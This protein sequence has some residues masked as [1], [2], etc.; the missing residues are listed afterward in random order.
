MRRRDD[1][2]INSTQV[3]TGG[4]TFSVVGGTVGGV[5]SRA[6]GHVDSL[7]I[8]TPPPPADP[9]ELAAA[10][11]TL[12]QALGGAA[13]PEAVRA[14]LEE[15]LDAARRAVDRAQPNPARAADRLGAMARQLASHPA[16]AAVLGRL[17]DAALD[18]ATRMA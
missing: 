10:L 1:K 16:A 13:L 7:S 3:N 14:D 8:G 9:R 12:A 17:V 2:A 5:N 18:L 15:D 11:V 6:R 4:G